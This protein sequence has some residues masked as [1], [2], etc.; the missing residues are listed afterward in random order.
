MNSAL[1]WS[2]GGKT[3]ISKTHLLLT[4]LEISFCLLDT[5]QVGPKSVP[6]SQLYNLIHTCPKRFSLVQEVSSYVSI[7]FFSFFLFF[8]SFLS[9]FHFTH[10]LELIKRGKVSSSSGQV[11]S[12]SVQVFSSGTAT[13]TR[14]GFPTVEN[15]GKEGRSP[16]LQMP[17]MKASVTNRTQSTNA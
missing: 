4:T 14:H 11:S 8:P 5:P 7:L 9:F 2:L 12:S 17:P 13:T 3:S 1:S 6:R 16:Q 15:Q 10:S